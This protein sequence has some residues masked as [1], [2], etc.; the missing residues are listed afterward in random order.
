MSDA[1][2]RVSE[3]AALDTTDIARDDDGSATV[4]VRRSKTDQESEGA[5]LYL[6]SPTVR[7][8]NTWQKAAT[9]T[10]GPLFWA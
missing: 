5:V 4:T 7:R 8:L 1:L 6:G 10:D 2:L 3:L 9:I